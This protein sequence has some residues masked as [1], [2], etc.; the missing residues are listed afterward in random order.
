MVRTG[1]DGPVEAMTRES[2]DAVGERSLRQAFDAYARQG[3]SIPESE[4]FPAAIAKV[5]PQ[6]RPG[7]A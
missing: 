7:A 5:K 6:Q 2:F 4:I 3:G 1:L